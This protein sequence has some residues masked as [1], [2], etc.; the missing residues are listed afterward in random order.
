MDP[1]IERQ[2]KEIFG[3]I[4]MECPLCGAELMIVNQNKDV[5][6]DPGTGK[7]KTGKTQVLLTYWCGSKFYVG[8]GC[9]SDEI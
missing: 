2:M 9:E 8:Q 3:N 5:W 1:D 7:I 4:P 6:R